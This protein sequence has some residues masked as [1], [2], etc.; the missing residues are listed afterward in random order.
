M[1]DEILKTAGQIAAA[2]GPVLMVIAIWALVTNRVVSAQTLRERDAMAAS[3]LA[4]RDKT[5]AKLEQK[6][7]DLFK[8]TFRF[9]DLLERTQTAASKVAGVTS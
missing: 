2:T 3:V 9:S 6:N 8:I 5:I 1:L 7:D 4:D